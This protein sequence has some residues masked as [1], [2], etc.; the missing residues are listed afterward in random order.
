MPRSGYI[1]HLYQNG[2]RVLSATVKQEI[3]HTI[4]QNNW[5]DEKYHLTMS[6]DNSI[7]E[8]TVLGWRHKPRIGDSPNT[9]DSIGYKIIK[10]GDLNASGRWSVEL[11]LFG[12]MMIYWNEQEQTWEEY[13]APKRKRAK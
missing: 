2:S 11:E 8:T 6:G 12:K 3:L 1:Y 10:V 5:T 4:H 9:I 7:G 13:E